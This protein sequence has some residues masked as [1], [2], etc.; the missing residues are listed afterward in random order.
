MDRNLTDITR[1]T[2]NIFT[3]PTKDRGQLFKLYI[4]EVITDEI[5][6]DNINIGTNIYF[7]R[8]KSGTIIYPEKNGCVIK[9]N[10]NTRTYRVRCH[11]NKVEEVNLLMIVSVDNINIFKIECEN[12][13]WGNII[14]DKRISPPNPKRITPYKCYLCKDTKWIDI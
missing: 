14:H 5:I 7:K 4:P 3:T 11:N 9:K 10:E 2:S 12:C 13:R 1:T 6:M 8:M